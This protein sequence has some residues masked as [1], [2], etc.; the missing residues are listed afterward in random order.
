MSQPH[1]QNANVHFESPTK[2]RFRRKETAV[3]DSSDLVA[4]LSSYSRLPNGPPA[5]ML[6]GDP[7]DLL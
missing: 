3:L 4:A 1:F 2:S 7:D 5:K 6:M